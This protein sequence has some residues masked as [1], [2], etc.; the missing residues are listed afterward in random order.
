MDFAS[1]KFKK[2][3]TELGELIDGSATVDLHK[4]TDPMQNMA[5]KDYCSAQNWVTLTTRG[6]IHVPPNMRN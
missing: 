5:L 1:V 4:S 2:V 3:K 6:R